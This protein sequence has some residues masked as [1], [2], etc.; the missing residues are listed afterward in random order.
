[1]NT[2][3]VLAAAVDQMTDY[4]AAVARVH[5]ARDAVAQLDTAKSGR[6]DLAA[7]VAEKLATGALD[8]D[9]VRRLAADAAL[10]DRIDA[11][12]AIA[13]RAALGRLGNAVCAVLRSPG[14]VDPALAFLDDRMRALVERVRSAHDTLGDAADVEAALRAGHA[15]AWLVLVHGAD[16][17]ESIR[18]AQR[19]LVAATVDGSPLWLGESVLPGYATMSGGQDADRLIRAHGLYADGPKLPD[20]DAATFAPWP[21]GSDPYD[22]RDPIWPT[23]DRPAFLRWLCG[24]SG[25]T[26]RVPTVDAMHTAEAET[27]AARRQPPE[28]PRDF[29]PPKPEHR[30]WAARAPKKRNY[31]PREE[32]VDVNTR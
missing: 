31:R 12:V 30:E 7:V 13:V 11:D 27:E 10:A 19:A 29:V 8:L 26:P 17:Y 14:A 22:R 28:A 18:N 21:G 24:E 9:N 32:V 2:P 15:D 4:V 1:M 5:A 25:L 3:D 20:V 16:E 23:T 6:V